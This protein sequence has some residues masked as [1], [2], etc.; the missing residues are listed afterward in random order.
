MATDITIYL[1]FNMDAFLSAENIKIINE[2]NGTNYPEEDNTVTYQML[3]DSREEIGS[4]RGYFQYLKSD[5][6]QVWVLPDLYSS[7]DTSE[8]DPNNLI[9]VSESDYIQYWLPKFIILDV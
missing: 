7:I 8:T 2:Q 4:Q 1:I 6:S 9:Q 3:Y 5:N